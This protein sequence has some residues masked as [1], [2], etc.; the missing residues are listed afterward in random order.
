ML[1]EAIKA[2]NP[3]ATKD[4]IDEGADLHYQDDNN[5]T[6]LHFAAE[7]GNA[8]CCKVLLRYGCANGI[9]TSKSESAIDLALRGGHIVAAAVLSPSGCIYK[10][11]QCTKHLTFISAINAHVIVK[12]KPEYGDDAVREEMLE[13]LEANPT[14]RDEDTAEAFVRKSRDRELAAE[15]G[16]GGWL[17][18]FPVVAAVTAP[19]ETNKGTGEGES[20]KSA[21]VVAA[22]GTVPPAPTPLG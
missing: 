3:V 13:N 4:H 9:L 10:C 8:E 5:W 16:G 22:P 20:S 11:P 14:Q 2:G 19:A 15:Q 18:C 21:V 7:R 17:D 12:H 1:L 6:P